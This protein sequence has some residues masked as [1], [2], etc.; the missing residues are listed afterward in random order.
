VNGKL[1]V[2]GGFHGEISPEH[3][4]AQSAGYVYD[5]ATNKWSNVAPMPE[6]FTHAEGVVVGSV[7][8][9]V[10]GYVGNH[11]GPGTTHVW[12]F[13]TAANQWSR[14]PD[15]PVQR[16]AGAAALVGHTIYFTGGMN[17]SRTIDEGTTYALD[18][19]NQAAGWAR[20]ADM[21]NPRNHV[22]AASLNGFFYVIGGQ[23]GQED[24]QVSQSEVDRY[25]P[26]T[27]TWTKVAS[28]PSGRS[29]ITSATFTYDGRIIV[30]GG[31][32]ASGTPQRTVYDYDPATNKW[33]LLGNLPAARSTMVAG[34][35]NGKLYTA[36][37]NGPDV[38]R[39]GWVGTF[40]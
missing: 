5:P 7:I 33:G 36:T 35:I 20:K 12:R 30:I 18:L 11:P 21:P 37:G 24:A 9:F 2:L 25:D 31:E 23:H 8:W 40:A 22:A 15:L 13:D 34:I 3:F 16:G 6:P 17:V 32:T 27:D 10:G 19:N 28:L 1:Y 38:T 29:H 39:E 14:G 4:I 26:S